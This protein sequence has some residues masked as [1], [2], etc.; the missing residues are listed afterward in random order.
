MTRLDLHVHT[1][2]SACA[3]DVMSPGQVLERA[4]RRKVDVLAITDHN[5]SAGAEC[6]YRMA[7]SSSVRVLPGMEITTREEVHL[8]ALFDDPGALHELAALVECNLPAGENDDDLFGYQL[9]YDER[10]EIIGAD[11]RLRQ[12]AVMLSIDRL[13]DEIRALGGLAIPAHVFRPRN[14]LTSQLGFIDPTSGYDALEVRWRY[15]QSGEYQLGDRIEGFAVMTGS[16]AHFLEDVGRHCLELKAPVS[17]L[18][19]LKKALS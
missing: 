19:D 10:D 18:C 15:W 17:G 7:R 4:E 11:D 16:D 14:S 13:V 6:A 2:L 9:V 5:A 1:A 8:L 12:T 3:E